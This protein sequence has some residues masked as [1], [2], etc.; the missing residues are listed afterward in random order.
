VSAEN[1]EPV[2]KH[3]GDDADA[4]RFSIQLAVLSDAVLGVSE[5]MKDIFSST[6]A[7]TSNCNTFSEVYWK[8]VQ[9]Y[10]RAASCNCF[11][12]AFFFIYSSFEN[13]TSE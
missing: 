9:L 3:F 12:K 10:A 11:C 4:S 6:L 5:K 13:F 2:K 7:F 1:L 8:L